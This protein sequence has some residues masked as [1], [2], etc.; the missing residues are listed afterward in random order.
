MIRLLVPSQSGELKIRQITHFIDM[1]LFLRGLN[2][3]VNKDYPYPNLLGESGLSYQI[4]QCMQISGCRIDIFFCVSSV[5][6]HFFTYLFI[7]SSALGLL[8][9]SVQDLALWSFRFPRVSSQA[10]M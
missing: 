10:V 6:H 2:K 7:R 9:Y 4:S 8:L 3:V 1:H 5:S